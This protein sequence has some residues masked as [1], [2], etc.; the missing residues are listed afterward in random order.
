MNSDKVCYANLIT[1]DDI[2]IVLPFIKWQEFRDLQ[3]RDPILVDLS[4]TFVEVCSLS[5]SLESLPEICRTLS[6]KNGT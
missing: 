5:K 1:V 6:Q 2:G 4:N 3:Y